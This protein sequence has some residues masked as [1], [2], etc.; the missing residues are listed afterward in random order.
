MPNSVFICLLNILLLGC[1]DTIFSKTYAPLPNIP[2]LSVT[3]NDSNLTHGI[4]KYVAD[5]VIRISSTSRIKL[6]CMDS[7]LKGCTNPRSMDKS[8]AEGY[9]RCSLYEGNVELYRIQQNYKSVDDKALEKLIE[10]LV[11]EIKKK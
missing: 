10:M 2:S 3:S 7:G 8:Y 1:E 6:I 5:H 11:G 9:I 4:E